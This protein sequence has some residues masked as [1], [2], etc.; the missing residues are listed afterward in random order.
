[1]DITQG[2]AARNPGLKPCHPFRMAK[3]FFAAFASF[4]RPFPLHPS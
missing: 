3:M 4:A 2:G 1:M